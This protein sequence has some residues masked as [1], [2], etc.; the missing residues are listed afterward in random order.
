MRPF[1]T[2]ELSPETYAMLQAHKTSDASVELVQRTARVKPKTA[3]IVS[4]RVNQIAD[5][6]PDMDAIRK[7]VNSWLNAVPE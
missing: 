3:E 2:L 6:T 4:L 7:E 5:K 1:P